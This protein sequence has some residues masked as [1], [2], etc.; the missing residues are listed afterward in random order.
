ME[1][2]L[3]ECG[4]ARFLVLLEGPWATLIVR[5]LLRGPLRFGELRESLPGISPHTL[6]SRLRQFETHGLVTRT[7]YAEVP[8]RVEYELTPLGQQ[9]RTVLDA[10][11]EWALSVP[12]AG[13]TR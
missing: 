7:V 10:M 3:P 5:E 4:V 2:E 9:L 6:T 13:R 1:T 12:A 11:A 8:P